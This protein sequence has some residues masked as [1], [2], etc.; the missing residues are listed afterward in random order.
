MSFCIQCGEAL[1]EGTRFC[2]SCGAAVPHPETPSTASA[3]VPGLG[4]F[5][6][7]KNRNYWIGGVAGCGGLLFLISVVVIFFRLVN[8]TPN[9]PSAIAVPAPLAEEIQAY[10]QVSHTDYLLEFE[11]PRD[12]VESGS[13]GNYRIE[14]PPGH[15]DAGLVWMGVVA[16]PNGPTEDGTEIADGIAARLEGIAEMK[17]DNMYPVVTR[18]G[19]EEVR[20]ETEV[21]TGEAVLLSTVIDFHFTDPTSGRRWR[22]LQIGTY[23]QDG[24]ARFHYFITVRA[25]DDRWA[26]YESIGARFLALKLGVNELIQP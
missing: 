24:F 1:R 6:T 11:I 18:P 13:Q 10:R 14:P 15:P 7:S 3:S 19:G 17:V 25:A 23:Q 4:R 16:T 9:D 20:G 21:T 12:W 5:V 8:Q 2:P 26:D 22:G